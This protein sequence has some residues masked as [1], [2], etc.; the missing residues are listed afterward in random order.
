MKSKFALNLLA[1]TLFGVLGASVYA[2]SVVPIKG[3]VSVDQLKMSTKGKVAPTTNQAA[4]EEKLNAQS[5]PQ[6][7]GSLFNDKSKLS[8]QEAQKPPVV[9]DTSNSGEKT[10]GLSGVPFTTTDDTADTLGKVGSLQAQMSLQKFSFEVD[11][12]IQQRI[13]FANGETS[14]S[15]GSNSRGARKSSSPSQAAPV[16]NAAPPP[17]PPRV[18]SV[19]SFGDKAF[20]EI[21]M[22][23]GSKY[24]VSPGRKLPNGMKVGKVHDGGVDLYSGRHSKFYPVQMGEPSVYTSGSSAMPRAMPS[25]TISSPAMPPIALPPIPSGR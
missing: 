13:D 15:H 4:V 7:G 16:L 1:M 17:A 19:Y 6:T 10:A 5:P 24:I 20:A 18:T 12:Q 21:T 25:S 11:K 14:D 22:G 8:S 23:D 3:N 2:Q 9:N